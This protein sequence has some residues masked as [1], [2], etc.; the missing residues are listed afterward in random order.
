[1]FRHIPVINQLNIISTAIGSVVQIGDSNMLQARNRAI[2]VQREQPFYLGIEGQFE[3]YNIFRD[4]EITIPTRQTSV[5]MH[6]TNVNP[7][8]SV[9]F[10]SLGS[11]EYTGIFHVGP[12]DY[13]FNNSRVLQI[14]HFISEE[15]FEETPSERSL[16][17]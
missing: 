16:I 14:R 10:V 13:V 6:V 1:M 12:I 3:G 7:F 2:L 5:C 17:P 9:D 4:T 8:I 11:L 15:P